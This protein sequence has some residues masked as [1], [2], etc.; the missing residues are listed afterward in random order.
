MNGSESDLL[1]IWSANVEA[2]EGGARCALSPEQ[3]RVVAACAAGQTEGQHKTCSFSARLPP[4]SRRIRIQGEVG[5]TGSASGLAFERGRSRA[6]RCIRAPRHARTEPTVR[7]PLRLIE[8]GLITATSQNRIRRL[9]ALHSKRRRIG[10]RVK[11]LF[12]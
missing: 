10:S 7:V 12:F 4:A 8:V 1:A 2:T 9:Q 5:L 6:R 3:S 11:S